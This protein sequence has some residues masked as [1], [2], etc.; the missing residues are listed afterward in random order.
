M[1]SSATAL[2]F[3]TALVFAAAVSLD[4]VALSDD[5]VN[6]VNSVQ[7]SWRAGHN[8]YFDGKSE[9][10]IRGLMGVRMDDGFMLPVKEIE[11]DPYCLA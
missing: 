3:L 7:S 2:V 6:Y 8:S 4:H 11:V 10:F 1:K 9:E 5:L